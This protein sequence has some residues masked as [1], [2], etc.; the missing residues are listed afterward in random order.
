MI[1]Q[2]L[3]HGAGRDSEKVGPISGG[4]CSRAELEVGLMHQRGGVQGALAELVPQLQPGQPAQIVVDQ[5]DQQL[6]RGRVSRPRA[7]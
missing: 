2:D 7:P 5:G 4:E 1:N 6:E 3:A